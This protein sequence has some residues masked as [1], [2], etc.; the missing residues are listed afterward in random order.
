MKNQDK[1]ESMMKRLFNPWLVAVAMMAAL[2]AAVV[3]GDAKRQNPEGAV[4][5]A[6]TLPIQDTKFKPGCLL[7][8][9]VPVYPP[10]YL[11]PKMKPQYEREVAA[12]YEQV[13]VWQWHIHNH[14]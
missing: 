13:R 1:G 2:S 11:D 5:F 10:M 8:M 4:A 3:S 12:Y 14:K 9:R 6:S 7:C